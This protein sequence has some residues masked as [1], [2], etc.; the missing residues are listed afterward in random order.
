MV[1]GLALVLLFSSARPVR[2]KATD[3]LWRGLDGF[4]ALTGV[5]KAFGDVLSYLRLFALG[6][7]SAS[8][9]V[10]FNQLGT[11]IMGAGRGHRPL[12]GLDGARAGT[13]AEL[14][15]RAS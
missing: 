9:A 6:L 10:T 15:A 1:A 2:K 11:D 3:V 12:L 5:S 8:L 14:R 13:R 4:Q 7:S